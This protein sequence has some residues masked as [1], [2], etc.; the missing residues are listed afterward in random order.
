MK[1]KTSIFIFLFALVS[2]PLVAIDNQWKTHF[3]YNSV[4]LIANCPEEVYALANGAIFSINKT[5]EKM[6]LYNNQLGMHG[7]DV[8][9]L[10]YDD[11]RKQ[12]LIMYSDGKMDIQYNGTMHYISDLYSKRITSSKVCNNIT[13]QDKFAYMAMDF[14]ILVFDLEKHEFKDAYYIGEEASEVKVTDVMFYGDSIYAQTKSKNYVVCI[15]DNVV[16]Y[17]FWK[18]CAVLPCPFDKKKGK[19]YTMLDGDFWKVA[20]TQGVYRKLVTGE[21]TYYLPD[22][23]QVNTPYSMT[24]DRG[25]LYVVPGGRW[26]NQNG[27]EGHVMIYENEKWLNIT[28]TQIK[29]KTGKRALDFMNVAVDPDDSEH[30][31][32]TSYGTGVYEFKDDVLVKHYTP[33]NSILGSAVPSSPDTYTRTCNAVY[34][35]ENRLWVL[36]ASDIDT[37]IVAFLPDG[38]QRGINLFSNNSRFFVN[39]PGG[40]I[41]DKFNPNRKWILSC[42]AIPAIAMI[43]DGGTRFDQSDDEFKVQSEFFDQDANVIVPE[44]YYEMRQAPNGDIW[45]GSSS[46][47]I[48]IPHTTDF[49][50]SKQCQR[51][52]IPMADGNYLLETERVNTFAFDNSNKIWIGTAQSGIYVLNE[53]A[54]EIVAH[55]TSENTVM[56]SNTVISL[57]FDDYTNRMYIGTGGGLVSYKLSPDTA[58]NS[59][60]SEEDFTYGTMYQWKSHLAYSE[61]NQVAKL[62]DKIFALSNNSL[63]SV[64]KRTEEIEYYTKAS[65]LSSSLIDHI[66]INK[67]IGKIIPNAPHETLLVIDATTGQNGISQAKAFKEITDITGIVLTKLD[68]TAKGGIVLAIKEN[69]GVPV[70]YIGLGETKEDLQV[71]DIEKYIYGLFKDL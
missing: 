35:N 41:V 7:T 71:F 6:T 14:G 23:P 36:V 68:G 65:G 5:T 66:E 69:I 22:G 30:F 49:L 54:T 64:N 45:I 27:A 38:T 47:P 51:L 13:I 28:N 29:N 9:F 57:A 10:M 53:E 34:D 4:E 11:E 32:V 44:F 24:F 18:T 39:T 62:E 25:R 67:E 55:Y 15:H 60:F 58:L 12:L 17:H 2:L 43:D 70:K 42:R 19:E 1:V 8:C 40:L 50:T 63:F 56:P 20:G 48:I 61:I 52:R 37:T 16:D 33:N 59:G 46:G 21:E 26:A 31:F 3:A